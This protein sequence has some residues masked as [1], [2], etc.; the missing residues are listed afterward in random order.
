MKRILI[1]GGGGFVGKNLT[2]NILKKKYALLAPTSKE[3]NLLDEAAV[4]DYILQNKI[5]IIIHGANI[6]GGRNTI[7]M[8]D[9]IHTNLRMF[10][11]VVRNT[12]LVKKIIHFGSGAEYDKSRPLQ[13]ISETE[14][15]KH[16]P[17]DDYGFY[18]Y[19]CSKYIE[20]D[21]TNKLVC[22]RLFGIYGKYE[23][24]LFKFI[25]NAI[26]KNLLRLPITIMQNVYFDYMYIS[27][28]APIISFFIEHTPKYNHY[29]I[30]TG[31][32]IDLI[33]LAGII[34]S[35]G[36]FKSEIFVRNPGLQ[37]EYSANNKRLLQ[38]VPV[39][40]T[41]HEKAIENLYAWYKK[42]LHKFDT[43]TIKKD[44]YIQHIKVKK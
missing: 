20:Q 12:R 16:V 15:D 6:G 43:E 2:E 23:N 11:N 40:F 7:G 3:L 22:L 35:I 4:T 38:E 30:A 34:N 36:S 29:N 19:V 1:T 31:K 5:E 42:N 9:T 26:V 27:D 18:K 33:T 32:K 17:Q 41:S 39:E 25:S 10:F 24:Y 21:T 13:S 28:L 44:P 37:N 8:V 14:F